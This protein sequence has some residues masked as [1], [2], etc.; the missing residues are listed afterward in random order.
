[1]DEYELRALKG[2]HRHIT[3]SMLAHAYFDPKPPARSKAEL[4]RAVISHMRRLT[5]YSASQAIDYC[6][7]PNGNKHR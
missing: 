3:L 5:K 2:W 4:K 6:N 1:M 7:E